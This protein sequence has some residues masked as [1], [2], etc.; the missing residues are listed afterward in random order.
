MREAVLAAERALAAGDQSPFFVP[1][2]VGAVASRYLAVAAPHS[3]A[4]VGAGAMAETSLLTHRVWFA[5]R[6]VRCTDAV[7]ARRVDGRV[8][9]LADALTADIVCIGEPIALAAGQLRRGSHVNALAGATLDDELAASAR[10][11]VGVPALAA[12]VAGHIGGRE[13]DELTIYAS[14]G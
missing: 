7:V 13:L 1:T 2:V 10:V 11:V 5:P 8:V 9:D 4:I 12:I 14:A 6:D 3:F